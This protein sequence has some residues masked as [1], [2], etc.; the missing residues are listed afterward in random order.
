MTILTIRLRLCDKHSSDLDR[1]ARA[2][3]FVWNYCN[4]TQKKAAQAGRTWL[5]AADLQRLTAGASKELSLHAHT[6]QKV[7]QQYDRSRSQKRK[8]WLRFRGRKSLGWVPFN[9]GH[10]TVVKQ[11]KLKFRGV[12]YETMHWRDLPV[13]SVICA[14]SFNQDAR[15]RWYV[16]L[17]IEFPVEAFNKSG[18]TVV[19]I[20]LGLKDL[21]T[22]S[23]GE[24]IEH[25]RHYRRHEERLGKAQR[26]RKTRYAKAIAAKI[27]NCRKDFIHKASARIALAHGLIFVGDVS[28]H[29]LARTSMA[30]SVLDASWSTL[31]TQLTYKAIRHGGRCIE[32]DE[33]M[34]TQ[35]CSACGS[36]PEGRPKGIANLGIR[37]WTCVECGAAHDRDVN[38][39]RNILRVGLDT[40]AEG[41]LA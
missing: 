11:G 41:A 27:A 26:A 1:Q 19:G 35:V 13:D 4:E 20:D 28:S 21:A 17:P 38:A 10:V 30:K 6:I 2:V 5:S 18:D 8:P 24:K 31:R 37:E 7:C 15:G 25:P 34:S 14:G 22:L 16:N 36:A 33:R 9:K 40:L 12:I 39:A 3:N 23:T 29:K 32:V